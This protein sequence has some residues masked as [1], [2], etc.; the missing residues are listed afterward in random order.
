M[1]VNPQLLAARLKNGDRG[2]QALELV[3]TILSH[4][5]T[6]I[7]PDMLQNKRQCA[8]FLSIENGHILGSML[9]N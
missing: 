6:K 8:H 7:L 2:L 5:R 9:Q 3:R 1:Q 4:V